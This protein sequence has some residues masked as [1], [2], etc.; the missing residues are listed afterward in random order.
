MSLPKYPAARSRSEIITLSATLT[1]PDN[2]TPYAAGDAIGTAS[3]GLA[4]TAKTTAS[5]N[6]PNFWPWAGRWRPFA[7]PPAT[8]SGAS[9]TRS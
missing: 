4:A 8:P 2:A 9:I 3:S 6:R 7:W 1:R 5:P